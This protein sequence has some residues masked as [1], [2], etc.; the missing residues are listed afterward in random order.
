MW[1]LPATPHRVEHLR[2]SHR[3]DWHCPTWPR[4]DWRHAGRPPPNL[5]RTDPHCAGRLRPD[6]RRTNRL[7]PDRPTPATPRPSRALHRR[8]FTNSQAKPHRLGQ[9]GGRRPP[10]RRAAAPGASPSCVNCAP[11]RSAPARFASCSAAWVKSAPRKVGVLRGRHNADQHS[12][13]WRHADPRRCKSARRRVGGVQIAAAQ[14]GA[15]QVPL[16]L[17]RADEFIDQTPLVVQIRVLASSLLWCRSAHSNLAPSRSAPSRLAPARRACCKS[18]SCKFAPA[19][20]AAARSAPA[21]TRPACGSLSD[22]PY[23]PPLGIQQRALVDNGAAQVSTV[24]HGSRQICAAQ[25]GRR[26]A[27][28]SNSRAPR[29]VAPCRFAP[30]RSAFASTAARRLASGS[31]A[32]ARLA[33]VRSA[34]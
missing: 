30:S 31:C 27:A 8:W 34:K 14:V 13:Q 15:G 1:R 12:R 7:R 21:S 32:P 23:H 18:A 9:C 3:T 33:P 22:G 28:P 2:A 20:L 29:K 25:V 10:W 24:K 16:V 11:R 6:W 17:C 19:R 5:H 4:R 26:P